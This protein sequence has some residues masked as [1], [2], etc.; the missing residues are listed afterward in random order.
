MKVALQDVV[1]AAIACSSPKPGDVVL[2][3]G[4]NDGTLLR[5]YPHRYCLRTVGVEPALNMKEEGSRGVDVF[6]NEFWDA[7]KVLPR[8]NDDRAKIITAIGMF[9]DLEDP[10]KFIA[11]VAT[12]LHPDGVFIAQLMCLK[13]TMEKRD[14]GNFAHEHL[15]FYTLK[16][17]HTLFFR[18][19]LEIFD[20]EENDINGGSY[21]LYVRHIG[22]TVGRQRE[23]LGRLE[24]YHA[25]ES[26]RNLGTRYV[27]AEIFKSWNDNRAK[28]L[29]FI[30]DRI[31]DGK[32]VYVYGAS[33]KGNVILQWLGLTGDD[34]PVALD[35]S[36]EKWGKYT[37]GSGIH[38]VSEEAGRGLL[39]ETIP[40]PDYMLVLPYAFVDEFVERE[41]QQEWRKRGGKFIVPLPEFRVL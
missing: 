6:V 17:L 7:R 21:R 32:R 1:N 22:S 37:A 39:S 19:G 28:C 23:K 41:S 4:S 9:Y 33:T 11:D 15:E 29:A 36:K 2:D 18:N 34:I 24:T 8:V 20:V 38:I 27:L 13:Q 16:S 31:M 12:V 10:N 35:K 30:A 40:M 5:C 26:M 25:I 3:I 14:I